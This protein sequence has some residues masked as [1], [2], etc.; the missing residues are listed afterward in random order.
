MSPLTK[1]TLARIGF[2]VVPFVALVVIGV[3]IV[4]SALIAT[5]A[6][7]V[8]SLFALRKLRGAASAQIGGLKRRAGQGE[9]DDDMA[10]EDRIVDNGKGR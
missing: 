1:Y 5:T 2:F 6:A 8:L 10:N 4:T 3:E 7:L 9:Y